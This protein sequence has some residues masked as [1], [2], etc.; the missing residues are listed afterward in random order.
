MSLKS[1]LL[2]SATAILAFLLIR[3]VVLPDRLSVDT[4]ASFLATWIGLAGLFKSIKLDRNK[5]SASITSRVL[6]SKDE[7]FTLS[8]SFDG[9]I[10]GGLI[11][12]VFGGAYGGSL[13]YNLVL[14]TPFFEIVTPIII[15]AA[16]S[17]AF[18][19]GS[20]QAFILFFQFLKK[21]N[22]VP[23]LLFNEITGGLLG[24]AFG[25][26]ITGPLAGWYFGQKYGLPVVPPSLFVEGMV[27]ACVVLII[28][29]LVF[30]YSGGL[31]YFARKLLISI[32][33]IFVFMGSFIAILSATNLYQS[34]GRYF[35][36][37][38]PTNLLYGGGL[39]GLITCS[40]LGLTI[41]F[42]IFI[43]RLSSKKRQYADS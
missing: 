16:L 13:Y 29:P 32:A 5:T 40:I 4:L 41:G 22:K 17:G 19:G 33:I 10:F 14:G 18:I 37:S 34:L 11:G 1:A 36:I 28:G 39:Y 3:N 21:E 43:F 35:R 24:G 8:A 2:I 30:N 38:T 25:G 9:G 31:L 42:T 12:G 15:F 27:P 6:S 23:S 7:V 26:V 20:C